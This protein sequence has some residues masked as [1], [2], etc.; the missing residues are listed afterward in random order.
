MTRRHINLLPQSFCRWQ[1]VRCRMRQ[2]GMIWIGVVV[3]TAVVHGSIG[4][5]QKLEHAKLRALESEYAPVRRLLAEVTSTRSMIVELQNR[6]SLALQIAD[7]QPALSLVGIVSRAARQCDRDIY[8]QHLSLV[9]TQMPNDTRDRSRPPTP[10]RKLTLE[11]LAASNLA[12][13]RFA[14]SLR[15]AQVFDSVALKS[16]GTP[17]GDEDDARSYQL[18]CAF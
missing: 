10:Q 1:I 4:D 5:R 14:A 13:A 16:A 3:C 15:D 2:W 11:G 17:A 12:V 7:E 6:E 18:E 9:R 8:V